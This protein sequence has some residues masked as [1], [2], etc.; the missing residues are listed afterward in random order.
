MSE[1][2]IILK[3]FG[4][5]PVIESFGYP[6]GPDRWRYDGEDPSAWLPGTLKCILVFPY[7]CMIQYGPHQFALDNDE[8]LL[9]LSQAQDPDIIS[10]LTSWPKHLIEI[11]D[12]PAEELLELGAEIWEQVVSPTY[13]LGYKKRAEEIAAEI[14]WSNLRYKIAKMAPAAYALFQ[15]LSPDTVDEPF[16]WEFLPKF[17][18]RCVDWGSDTPTLKPHAKDLLKP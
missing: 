5:K 9:T 11:P 14:G 16:D 12:Y 1:Q 10:M 4:P 18:D 6:I 2:Y 8:P 7:A 3:G 13:E 15:D 17:L